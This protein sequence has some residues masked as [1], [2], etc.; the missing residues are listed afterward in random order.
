M[1]S[2][3]GLKTSKVVEIKFADDHTVEDRLPSPVSVLEQF[4]VEESVNSP[5]TISLATEPP[6]EPFYIHIE[7][8]NATSLL[9][10]QLDLKS[11]A[12]TSKDKQG[13]SSE[14]IRAVLQVS[15]LNWGELSRR[16]LLLDQMPD[17]SLFNNVEVWLEKSYTERRLFFG[18]ISEVILEIYQ[19]YFGCSLW[20]S[21][22]YPRLQWAMLSKNLVH[23]VLR[24]VDW[25]L[26]LELPQQTLQQLVENDLHKSGI[27]MDN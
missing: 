6:V 12:G 10:S 18:Y 19:C 2:S 14:S 4:F 23:E 9:E 1:D 16:W 26:L 15:G 13:S 17:A 8:H 24:H 11:T 7:E 20:I 5:S 22:L 25:Q 27:W 3:Y 21:L